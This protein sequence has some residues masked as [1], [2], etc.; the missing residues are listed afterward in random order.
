MVVRPA[1]LAALWAVALALHCAGQATR[2]KAMSET[3]DRVL[4]WVRKAPFDD[5]TLKAAS[6]GF[7]YEKWFDEGRDLPQS[8]DVLA[9][10]LGE[11]DLEK[12][13]GDGMRVAYALGW[14]GD[15]RRPVI[16][17]LVRSVKSKDPALRME[18]VAA[19]GRLREASVLPMLE[20]LLA[21]PK[22]DVNVRGNACISIG[23]LGDPASEVLLKRTAESPDAFLS[24]CAKEALR[25]S[26]DARPAR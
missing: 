14:I 25:L 15:R 20:K 3:R 16:D 9:Q 12:P 17:G 13:S 26:K 10:V 11:E 2:S 8:I 6:P 23:R 21:D 24:A 22:E 4:A 18:A 7:S 1:K 19:L 5:I